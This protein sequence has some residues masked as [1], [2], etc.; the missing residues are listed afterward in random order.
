MLLKA[1]LEINVLTSW[2]NIDALF[3]LLLRIWIL[4]ILIMISL[5]YIFHFI[6]FKEEINVSSRAASHPSGFSSYLHAKQMRQT[7]SHVSSIF[8][9]HLPF[10]WN[11]FWTENV[12]LCPQTV[13]SF[14]T[15]WLWL[16]VC[17]YHHLVRQWKSLR[18]WYRFY[19]RRDSP[20]MKIWMRVGR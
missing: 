20:L 10:F 17:L 5:G 16:L 12:V 2:S 3:S 13:L 15:V 14:A 6:V 1:C 18:W 11:T 7:K 8:Y 9:S 19:K 4:V